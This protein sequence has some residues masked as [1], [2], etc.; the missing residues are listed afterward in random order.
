MNRFC[1][2]I[3]YCL[4]LIS[5]PRETTKRRQ[6]QGPVRQKVHRVSNR[7]T[8]G[9]CWT[10]GYKTPPKDSKD[11]FIRWCSYDTLK[12]PFSAAAPDRSG[13]KR[14]TIKGWRR[15]MSW[16]K[17]GQ[18]HQDL[19]KKTG[20]WTHTRLYRFFIS[21]IPCLQFW[22]STSSKGQFLWRSR[23]S[24]A[25]ERGLSRGPKLAGTSTEC[26]MILHDSPRFSDQTFGFLGCHWLKLA[27]GLPI[28]L[29]PRGKED[30]R[31][32]TEAG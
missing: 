5:G 18:L 6:S 4:P 8:L 23:C 22:R 7:E 1:Q 19:G 15:A 2:V 11:R 14:S 25:N 10:I 27:E 16:L 9:I 20:S 13:S 12:L 24:R 3:C 30:H 32:R 26:S 28:P 21:T 31:Q 29:I 17:P